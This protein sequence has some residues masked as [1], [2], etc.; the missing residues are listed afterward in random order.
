ML[1]FKNDSECTAADFTQQLIITQFSKRGGVDINGKARVG[2]A[3]PLVIA[4]LHGQTDIARLLIE[5]GADL[6]IP[7]ENGS[8]PL[9]IAAFF[10]HRALVKLLLDSG[11][12]IN[13]KNKDDYPVLSVACMN[14]QL[15]YAGTGRKI[16]NINDLC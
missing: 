11:A 3:T 9:L 5:K 14:K 2:K 15:F 10:G 1:G 16:L 8:S 6:S 13:A 7:S 4:A 12:D